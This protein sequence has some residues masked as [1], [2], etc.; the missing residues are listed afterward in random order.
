MQSQTGG[1]AGV[2]LIEFF[3]WRRDDFAAA[4]AACDAPVAQKKRFD[5][6]KT[7]VFAY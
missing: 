4:L 6:I 1:K 5:A 2:G 3:V 7:D